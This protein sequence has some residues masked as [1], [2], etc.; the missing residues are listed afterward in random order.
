MRPAT[1]DNW[2]DAVAAAWGEICHGHNGCHVDRKRESYEVALATRACEILV[3]NGIGRPRGA[4]PDEWL[5]VVQSF[6]NRTPCS[7]DGLVE[8]PHGLRLSI[9]NLARSRDHMVLH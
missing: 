8:G 9:K 7:H 1:I 4:V 3:N 5:V 6:A 2:V